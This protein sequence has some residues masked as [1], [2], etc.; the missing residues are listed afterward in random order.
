MNL[1]LQYYNVLERY[2]MKIDELKQTFLMMQMF[3]KLLL[4]HYTLF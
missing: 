2:Q 4:H 3:L 1:K